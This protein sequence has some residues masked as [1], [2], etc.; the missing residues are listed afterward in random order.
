MFISSQSLI[1]TIAL[2]T[3]SAY[4]A[5][6]NL[7][8]VLRNGNCTSLSSG[9]MCGKAVTWGALTPY[10]AASSPYADPKID[11]EC[12][13]TF[14]QVLSRH[15]SR[16]PTRDIGEK[17]EATLK[18]IQ[19]KA[20]SYSP[21][22]E[23]IKKFKYDLQ[24]KYELLT[25]Y[26]ENE[27]YQ[28]GQ[29]F[30]SRYKDITKD[31]DPYVRIAGQTRV[32]D[33]GNKFVKGFTSEK[34]K[35][36]GKVSIQEPMVVPEGP[37]FKN[38]LKHGTCKAFETG[39]Y[40]KSDKEPLKTWN[41]VFA[42]P[43]VERLKKELPGA[44][45]N[46]EDVM[47]LLTICPFYTVLRG[48][49]S[50]F[51]RL[52]TPEEFKQFNYYQTLRKYYRYGPGNDLGPAQ[53]IGFVNELIGRL[54]NTEVKDSTSTNK[55]ATGPVDKKLY[56]DFTHDNDMVAVFSALQLFKGMKNLDPKKIDGEDKFNTADLVPFASRMYVEKLKCGG[57]DELVRVLINERVMKL[58]CKEKKFGGCTV[59]DFI[60]GLEF[61]RK[62]G[63]WASC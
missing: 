16:Y 54:T 41:S 56:A 39:K 44:D 36:G 20:T 23:F 47:S 38:T 5:A 11:S 27:L 63:N 24:S 25:E 48:D 9:L 26:G 49:I 22:T 34:E 10:H 30:F 7:Q 50:E 6:V 8:L 1:F 2:L 28:S 57:E 60:D 33:S 53:G 12:K 55:T 17:L 4:G 32:I 15:G 45:I 61:A 58:N 3:E 62:G 19:S 46:E 51:C 21:K 40:S 35:A 14:A 13:V 43:I 52:F 42:P 18:K 59:K 31:N 29:T 37:G